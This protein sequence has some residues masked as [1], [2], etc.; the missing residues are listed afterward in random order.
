MLKFGQNEVT[1]K[2]FYEQRQITDLF[3]IDINQ[4]GGL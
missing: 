2:D 3:R 4:L 1:T